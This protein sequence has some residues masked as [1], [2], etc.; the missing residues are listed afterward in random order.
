LAAF[1]RSGEKGEGRG[2]K[3]VARVIALSFFLTQKKKKKRK[4]GKGVIAAPVGGLEGS[5]VPR[6]GRK[7]RAHR[8]DYPITVPRKRKRGGKK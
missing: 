3:I 7:K 4:K 6:G 1:V 5:C 2:K 8:P